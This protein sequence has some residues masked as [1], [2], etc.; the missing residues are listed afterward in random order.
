MYLYQWLAFTIV[1]QNWG[2]VWHFLAKILQG[3]IKQEGGATV[4]C[5]IKSCSQQAE[6]L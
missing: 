5:K 1:H 4:S 6:R 2:I 3:V